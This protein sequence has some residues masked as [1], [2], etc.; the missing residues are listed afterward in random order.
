[1]LQHEEV[2]PEGEE[3]LAAYLSGSLKGVGPKTAELLVAG[4]GTTILD[5][6]DSDSAV[7]R[8]A[9]VGGGGGGGRWALP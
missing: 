4:L 5:V 2:A 1:V 9:K 7:A 6:L 8:L 3:G